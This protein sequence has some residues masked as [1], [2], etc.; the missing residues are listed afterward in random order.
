MCADT[1]PPPPCPGDVGRDWH[2][3]GG[4]ELLPARPG[5]GAG[6]GGGSRVQAGPSSAEA[7]LAPARPPGHR[8]A[9]TTAGAEPR[10]GCTSVG[11]RVDLRAE[12]G[13]NE[14]YLLPIEGMVVSILLRNPAVI[15]PA[16]HDSSLID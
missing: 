16:S 8:R 13:S 5:K 1:V 14:H 4:A 15:I 7:A 11:K 3:G 6:G 10:R 12:K 9:R 2:G